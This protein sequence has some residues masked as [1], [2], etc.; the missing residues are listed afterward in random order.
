MGK[1][2][3]EQFLTY[4]GGER[5]RSPRTVESYASDLRHFEAYFKGLDNRLSWET[6]DTDIIRDWMESMMDKGN[7][8]TSI[9]RRLSAVRSFYRFALSKGIVGHDPTY[10]LRGP[11]KEKPLPQFVKEGEMDALLDL[12]EWGGTFADLR[13]RTIVLL[14]YTTGIRLAEL[15][16]LDDDSIDFGLMQIRVRGKRDKERIVPFGDELADALRTYIERRDKEFP[17]RPDGSALFVGKDGAR[18]SRGSVQY[19]VRKRLT[20]A[21]TLKKR[22]PHVLR[23]SF[24]TAMLNHH[25]GLES[26]KK[27]LGHEK[28]STTQIYTHV[29]FEQLR[30]AYGAAH[31]RATHDE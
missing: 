6:V 7:T 31:P 16:G 25:A 18:I 24:A 1:E 11:K 9:C 4:M 2:L 3:T 28:L 23:H 5:N 26:V 21:T 10:G 12:S 14:F 13:A 20:G 17:L 19:E 8:A 27:L 30:D 22:S 29:T 15:V